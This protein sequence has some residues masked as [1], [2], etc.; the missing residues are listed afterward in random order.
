MFTDARTNWLFFYFIFVLSSEW[1][2]EEILRYQ[3]G[4]IST[5]RKLEECSPGTGDFLPQTATAA[6]GEGG[7]E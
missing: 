2:E 4:Y 1:L 3:E 5:G 7:Q 6:T